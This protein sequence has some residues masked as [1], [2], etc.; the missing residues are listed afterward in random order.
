MRSGR[1]VVGDDDLLPGGTR[2]GGKVG[3]VEVV[4]VVAVAVVDEDPRD[5]Q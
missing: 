2:P 4:D 3:G 1:Q 5:P